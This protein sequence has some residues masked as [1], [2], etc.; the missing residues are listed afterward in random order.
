[1]SQDLK[2]APR[3]PSGPSLFG[4]LKPY[5]SLVI[6]LVVMTI[7]A[8]ALNL[9]VPKLVSHAIDSYGQQ[10]LVLRTLIVQFSA[11]ALGVFL[12]SYLQIVFQT[13]ASERVA[14]DLRTQL[15]GKISTQDNEFIL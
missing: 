9:V 7:V 14:R 6:G 1:M 5:R 10:Q 4:I 2:K 8:N 13:Y 12:F 15:I 11:V 3:R